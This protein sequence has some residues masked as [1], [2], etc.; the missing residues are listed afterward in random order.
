VLWDFF[1]RELLAAV[2]ALP[3]LLPFFLS[4]LPFHFEDLLQVLNREEDSFE[5][6]SL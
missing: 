3:V 4:P 5:P 1:E 6:S 2:P